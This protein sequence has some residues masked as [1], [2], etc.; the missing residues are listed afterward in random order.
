MYPAK[1]IPV[2]SLQPEALVVLAKWY[3][4]HNIYILHRAY[5]LALSGQKLDFM[6]VS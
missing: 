2:E 1:P 6:S 3:T 4:S 5:Q